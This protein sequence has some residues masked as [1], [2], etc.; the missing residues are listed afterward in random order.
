LV[1]SMFLPEDCGICGVVLAHRAEAR[2]ADGR[3]L[4]A[5]PYAD[6]LLRPQGRLDAVGVRGPQFHAVHA[7]L[8]ETRDDGV[9]VPRPG[10]VV[11]DRAEPR[12]RAR[13]RAARTRGL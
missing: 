7:D 1:S 2:Q 13:R 6:A 8:R 5:L 3:V 4:E 9:D 11:G 12:A 10:D